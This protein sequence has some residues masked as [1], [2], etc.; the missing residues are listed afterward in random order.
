MDGEGLCLNGKATGAT[1]VNVV[2][3]EEPK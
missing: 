1:T 3:K 2:G